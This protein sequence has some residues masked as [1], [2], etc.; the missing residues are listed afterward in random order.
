MDHCTNASTL[1]ELQLEE[2]LWKTV[3]KHKL[4]NFGHAVYI[5]NLCTKILE[6]RIEGKRKP[7]RPKRRWTDDIKDWINK[8]VATDKQNWSDLRPSAMRIETRERTSVLNT[9]EY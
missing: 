7:G 6:R 9:E 2:R 8:S 3:Q 1:E 4:Q 5:G